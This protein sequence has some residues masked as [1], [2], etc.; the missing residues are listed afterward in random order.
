MKP[1]L[2]LTLASGHV[3]EIPT[4]VIAD[5]RAAYYFKVCPDDFKTFAEAE[6]D[7]IGYFDDGRAITEWLFNSMD[8]EKIAKAHG[9][10]VAF[11]PPSV[12]WGDCEAELTDEPATVQALSGETIMEMPVSMVSASMAATNELCAAQQIM[13]TTTGQPQSAI[14]FINGGPEVVGAYLGGIKIITEKVLDRMEAA[15]AAANKQH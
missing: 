8:V 9:R 3:F 12:D 7:T 15:T 11:D 5:D 2:Q 13:D 14:V 6:A 10:L 1:Y 4:K